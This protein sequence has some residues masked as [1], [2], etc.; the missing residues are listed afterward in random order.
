MVK[1]LARSGPA[2]LRFSP[3]RFAPGVPLH[4]SPLRFA[5]GVPLHFSPLRFAPGVPLHFRSNNDRRELRE[6]GE[7]Y[8][9]LILGGGDN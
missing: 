4:F 6:T 5:P 1:R 9:S 2:P 8:V 3:L 7:S